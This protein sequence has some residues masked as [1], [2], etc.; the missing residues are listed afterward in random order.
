MLKELLLSGEMIGKGVLL[1]FVGPAAT[2]FTSSQLEVG[3]SLLGSDGLGLVGELPVEGCQDLVVI[4]KRVDATNEAA[5]VDL[6]TRPWRCSLDQS[7]A[8]FP[9]LCS[10]LGPDDGEGESEEVTLQ[11]REPGLAEVA[12]VA[13]YREDDGA[14]L[15]SRN[16]LAVLKGPDQVVDILG[17]VVIRFS[18]QTVDPDQ[19]LQQLS[20]FFEEFVPGSVAGEL[21]V[22]VFPVDLGDPVSIQEEHQLE[23]CGLDSVLAVQM[24]YREGSQPPV[25][26]SDVIRIQSGTGAGHP[27]VV[28]A[29]EGDDEVGSPSFRCG[30]FK[31]SMRH[32]STQS[33]RFLV[34]GEC[35]SSNQEFD[36]QRT[37]PQLAVKCAGVPACRNLLDGD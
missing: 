22:I 20:G 35:E 33:D 32:A 28:F 16:Q 31:A 23:L 8:L 21:D 19:E 2:S 36:Q 24:T 30:H 26:V 34:V 5:E 18:H 10:Y 37:N 3:S 15:V 13:G 6:L 14:E 12:R 25:E 17:R 7:H 29:A 4:E 1:Y 27:V 9:D 11:G